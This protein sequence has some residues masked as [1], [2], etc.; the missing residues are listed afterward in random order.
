MSQGLCGK[1]LATRPPDSLQELRL[2][3]PTL[4]LCSGQASSNS[5]TSEAAFF[6]TAPGPLPIAAFQSV[7][8][9]PQQTRL[10]AAADSSPLTMHS[11]WSRKL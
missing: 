3:V 11:R 2:V 6:G 9:I 10:G 5:A 7:F 1:V 8:G 4:R